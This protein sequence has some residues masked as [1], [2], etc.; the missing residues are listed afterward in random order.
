MASRTYWIGGWFPSR[1]DLDN[2][3]K[4]EKFCFADYYYY[5]Y[6]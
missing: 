2:V 6:Y 5:Y 3:E 1:A 4:R